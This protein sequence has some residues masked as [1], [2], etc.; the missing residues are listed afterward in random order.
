LLTFQLKCKL[1]IGINDEFI[2]II[3]G[4]SHQSGKLFFAVSTH[5][6]ISFIFSDIS[7]FGSNSIVMLEKLFLDVEEIFLI[8]EI[9]SISHS[10]SDVTKLSIS[11]A[12]A[13]L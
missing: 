8:Q 13:Q 2:L 4:S 9:S 11:T 7:T 5:D 6:L 3:F 1:K 10:I 12:F